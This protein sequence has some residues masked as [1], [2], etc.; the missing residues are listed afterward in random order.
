MATSTPKRQQGRGKLAG[1][2]G[3]TGRLGGGGG[4]AHEFGRALAAAGCR[5]PGGGRGEHEL[6]LAGD[7][8][9][10]GRW[11]G[12]L[13]AVEVALVVDRLLATAALAVPARAGGR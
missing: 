1:V 4:H 10:A 3:P 13:V 11:S 2:T 7:L 6:D 12:S 8:D 5:P 9:P